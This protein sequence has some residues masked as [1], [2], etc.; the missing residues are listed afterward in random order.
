M[1]A[2]W[3]VTPDT[4]GGAFLEWECLPSS[5]APS[6]GVGGYSWN[7]LLYVDHFDG[8]GAQGYIETALRNVLGTG[9]ANFEGTRWDRWDVR[10]PSSA[11]CSFG[12]PLHAEYGA[13]IVQALGYSDI[14]WNSGN[15]ASSNLVKED[16]D[17]LIPWLT[18]VS[19]GNNDLYLSGDGIVT[20]PVDEG[21]A[22]PSARALIQDLAGLN[23]KCR[24]FRSSTCSGPGPGVTDLSPCLFLDP[25]AGAPVAVLAS[26]AQDH[27]GQGNGCP[28]LRSFDVIGLGTPDRGTAQGDEQYVGS[29]KTVTYASTATNANGVYGLDY[30]IVV[31]GLSLHYRRD[32]GTA[33]DFT[34]GGANSITERM[35]EVANYLGITGGVGCLNQGVVGLPGDTSTH[36]HTTLGTFAPN[37]LRV[38]A[39]G[40]IQFTMAH[41][42]KAQVD[43]YDVEGRWVRTVF[44]GLAAEGPNEAFWDGTSRMGGSVGNGVYFYRLRAGGEDVSKRMVV[45]RGGE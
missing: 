2:S 43:I 5:T 17:V 32:A 9:S 12:R 6:G 29:S 14:V 8:R 36:Q 27:L 34:L 31:D 30:R 25:A 28:N 39:T 41:E 37:P 18:L 15:L 3:F 1:P 38:G 23:L 16:G 19:Y 11:Q 45:V 26:R 13:S 10:A 24:T 21:P 4:T 7:C 22:E 42:G 40:R 33:C 44:D 20:S 35:D